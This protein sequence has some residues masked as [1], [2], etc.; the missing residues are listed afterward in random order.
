MASILIQ[1]NSRLP[2]L[3]NEPKIAKFEVHTRKLWHQKFKEEIRKAEARDS[4]AGAMTPRYGAMVPSLL[5][6]IESMAPQNP[7]QDFFKILA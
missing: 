3:F 4:K 5:Y 6:P 7:K 1:M 2:K